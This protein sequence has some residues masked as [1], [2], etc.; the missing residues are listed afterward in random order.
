MAT[1]SNGL[2]SHA[3]EH[4]VSDED[5]R[6]EET[7]DLLSDGQRSRPVQRPKR[8]SP[9]AEPL[10]STPPRLLAVLLLLLLAVAA[11]VI[12]WSRSSEDGPAASSLSLSTVIQPIAVLSSQPI[13]PAAE[14]EVVEL[15]TGRRG[16]TRLSQPLT[17]RLT[18]AVRRLAEVVLLLRPALQRDMWMGNC[19][20]HTPC[21][22]PDAEARSQAAPPIPDSAFHVRLTS[23]PPMLS[24]WV[25]SW[26]SLS[27][28]SL[29]H[30]PSAPPSDTTPTPLT[31]PAQPSP[32]HFAPGETAHGQALSQRF[33]LDLHALQHPANCS[34]ATFLILDRWHTGGGF[35]SWNHDRSIPLALAMRVNRTLIEAPSHNEAW[36]YVIAWNDCVRRRGMGGCGVFLPAT[37]CPLDDDW[38][39]AYERERVAFVAERG[40]WSGAGGLD[41]RLQ[42]MAPRRWVAWTELRAGMGDE[43]HHDGASK[44]WEGETLARL[45][46]RLAAFR[47]M[48]ECWWMRQAMAYNQRMT[49][50]GQSRVAEMLTRS[51]QLPQPLAAARVALD[52]ADRR[53]PSVNHTAHWWLL[54]QA[55]KVAW[56]LHTLAP[57]LAHA[58]RDELQQLH[59]T[60]PASPI[61]EPTS[62]WSAVSNA[63]LTADV[64]A[65]MPLLGFTFVRH[66]DKVTEAALIPDAEHL[67]V[68]AMLA[69]RHGVR[70]W[71]VGADSLTSADA[72]RAANGNGTRPLVV[73]SSSVVDEVGD[74]AGHPM[75]GGFDRGAGQ[76]VSDEVREGVMWSTVLHHGMAQMA[77]VFAASWASNHVRFAYEQA[78]TMSDDRAAAPMYVMDGTPH[79]IDRCRG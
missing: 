48:P 27:A 29:F 28:A 67:R 3:G 54:A 69:D 55:I 50:M 17:A 33:Q 13:L 78:T 72:I 74:K 39:V 24:Q 23:R 7:A 51:L 6:Q 25:Q 66:G 34:D 35:G 12:V 2:R 22:F 61:A 60:D 10:C 63:T 1:I 37:H 71:Y 56:Q 46:E 32:S 21:P 68:A 40:E 5:E 76:V 44:G 73:L 77:D 26:H 8:S 49:R 19:L 57:G 64:H 41:E 52:Y 18:T 58:L 30:S 75:A 31:S 65:R 20:V 14:S 4:T 70:V 36:A 47:H 43:L 59:P 42:W 45:P 62:P 9:R 16:V 79:L 15:L 11:V 53:A 38:R